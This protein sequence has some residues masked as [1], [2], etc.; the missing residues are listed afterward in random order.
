MKKVEQ[1]RLIR[2]SK[3]VEKNTPVVKAD[4]NNIL[5]LKDLEPIVAAYDTI[6]FDLFDTVVHRRLSLGQIFHKT[7]EFGSISVAGENGDVG[8]WVFQSARGAVSQKIKQRSIKN[9]NRNEIV[10]SEV[11]DHCLT[12]Y[13]PSRR[14]RKTAVDKLVEFEVKQECATLYV[15]PDFIP[16]AKLIKRLDKRLILISDMYHREDAIVEILQHLGISDFFDHVFVSAEEGVTKHSGVLFDRVRDKLKLDPAGCL[17]IGDNFNN[18]FVKPRAH[19]WNSL[20]YY[21][22]NF[23]VKRLTQ[24]KTDVVI[25]T[26]D[27]LQRQMADGIFSKKGKNA[28]EELIDGVIAPAF[29]SFSIQLLSYASRKKLDHQYYLSRDGLVFRKIARIVNSRLP[30][31]P[32]FDTFSSDLAINRVSAILLTYENLYHLGW[33]Q[34]AVSWLSG[35]PLSLRNL[36]STFSCDVRDLP[37]LKPEERQRVVNSLDVTGFADTTAYLMSDATVRHSFEKLMRTKRDT[38]LKYLRQQKVTEYSKIGMVDIGYSGTIVKFLSQH[39]TQNSN[40]MRFSAN[41]IH[42]QFFATNRFYRNNMREMHP[43]V[44]FNPGFILNHADDNDKPALMNFGWLEPFALEPNLGRLRGYKKDQDGKITPDFSAPSNVE[45]RKMVQD[46]ILQR[47]ESLM[48]QIILSNVDLS[49]VHAVAKSRLL[50]FSVNPTARQV[51]AMREMQHDFGNAS[52]EHKGILKW[53][54]PKD[55]FA[56]KHLRNDDVWLQGSFKGT[57]LGFLNP[58]V[59]RWAKTSN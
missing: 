51:R 16:I 52:V 20:H 45:H 10:L 54:S 53:V 13:F 7:S 30:M 56:L 40:L 27:V 55:L 31:I 32:S 38:V 50:A 57:K 47:C 43:G 49:T 2:I 5:S 26:S 58:I 3:N 59:N 22:R 4:Q 11:F 35:K 12:P 8:A 15:D 25:A 42:C 28:L 44:A 48:D 1:L 39:M 46:R 14:H 24:D 19:G 9:E 36:L 33:A 37:D 23:E 6:S 41:Q 34:D 29:L 21:N 17:H 18:D